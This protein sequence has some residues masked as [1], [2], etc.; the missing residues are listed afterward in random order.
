MKRAV[1]NLAA[2]VVFGV[3][4]PALAEH[5]PPTRVVYTLKPVEIFGK[6]KTPVAAVEIRKASMSMSPTELRQP[7]LDRID[8]TVH[9]TSL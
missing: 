9:S 3:S 8:A 5:T 2:L 6:V 7:L 4:L 1:A